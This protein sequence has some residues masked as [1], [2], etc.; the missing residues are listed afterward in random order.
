MYR[1]DLTGSALDYWKEELSCPGDSLERFDL[2]VTVLG[3]VVPSSNPASQD[4]VRSEEA[5]WLQR[6]ERTVGHPE[7]R[8]NFSPADINSSCFSYQDLFLPEEMIMSDHLKLFR[9]W[10]PPLQT[11]VRR[12]QILTVADPLLHHSRVFFFGSHCEPYDVPCDEP[13]SSLEAEPGVEVFTKESI[14]TAESLMLPVGIEQAVVQ[15]RDIMLSIT[16]LHETLN[17]TPE[18]AEEQNSLLDALRK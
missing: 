17:I 9:S 16:G 3:E 4:S 18:P 11:F 1:L 2:G 13:A 15:K 14:L 8:D 12:L 7:W 6:G 5:L 10:L